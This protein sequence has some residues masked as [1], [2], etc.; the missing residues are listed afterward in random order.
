MTLGEPLARAREVAVDGWALVVDDQQQPQGWLA[1]DGVGPDGLRGDVTPDLL[2]LGGTLAS[3]SGT[4]R[5]LLDAALSAPSGRGVVV[6]EKERLVGTVTAAAVVELIESQ[7]DRR[8]TSG[9]QG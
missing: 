6:D 3:E 9:A 2:N 7:S 4:L 8:R 1:L 5:E